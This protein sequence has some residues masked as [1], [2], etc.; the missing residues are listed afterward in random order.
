MAIP[1]SSF[2]GVGPKTAE[3]LTEKGINSVETL[4]ES[5]FDVLVAAPGFSEA[6]A[7]TVM[8]AAK[9]VLSGDAPP[10]VV[11]KQAAPVAKKKVA[12]KAPAK[13]SIAKKA[14][15]KKAV[16]KKTATKKAS[17]E[18]VT[19]IGKMVEDA[20]TGKG[21]KAKKTRL[22]KKL[23][24][25]TLEK[26]EKLKQKITDKKKKKNKSKSKDKEKSKKK[27]KSKGKGKK[28]KS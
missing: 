8:A 26:L 23:K 7:N 28:K 19:V 22:A 11:K 2:P 13:K 15:T 9:S 18:N 1:V 10:R 21:K 6:R 20:E 5:G 3:Y 12:K 27:D 25:K 17:I 24:K 14:A 4:L 16:K